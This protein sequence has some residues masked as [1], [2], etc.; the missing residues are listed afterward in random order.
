VK[1]TGDKISVA[2]FEKMVKESDA[3]SEEYGDL[4]PVYGRQWREWETPARAECGAAQLSVFSKR[5]DQLQD[6]IN[7]LR[8]NPKSRRHVVVAWNPGEVDR[9]ALPP[10]HC[11]FQFN[12]RP[13]TKEQLQ[14][15]LYETV[16]EHEVWGPPH[17]ENASMDE[18][19]SLCEERDLPTRIL[20]L[21]MYQRSADA[22]LGV[23]FNVAS[24]ALLTHMIAQITGHQV[25]D[26]IHAF[27][28]AHIYNNHKA[29]V[30]EQLSRDPYPMPK[31]VL[32]PD[33][34]EIDGFKLDDIKLVGYQC[35]PSIKAKMA[36]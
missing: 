13:M 26:F 24:Y 3:F 10:C 1:K 22:F 20:D 14:D 30:A 7:R 21:Q 28:D 4:G 29:Q 33:I 6:T 5:V 35:H 9:M 25:G 11:L 34:K 27:G 18:L 16:L 12:S 19:V 36:V 32:N 17:I 23:P 31:I 15:Q 8:Q 2:D